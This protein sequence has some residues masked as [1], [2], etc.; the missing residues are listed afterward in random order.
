MAQEFETRVLDI[1]VK[2]I[3]DKLTKLGAK[4]ED[5]VLMKRWVFD[6]D[7]P[8]QQ[9]IRLRD[10][11]KK[12]TI[13]YKNRTGSGISE[14][15]ELEVEVSDF[16]ESAKILSK[17]KFKETFYQEN[18]RKIF[19]LNDIEFAIDT[20]P[21]IPPYLEIESD[22]EEKVKEGLALL[23]LQG[24]DVGNISVKETYDRYGVKLHSFKELRF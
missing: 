15:E 23:G 7:G 17:L 14:T 11:G 1:D 6:I 19:L 18:K 13:A 22:S 4:V 3:E 12:V 8:N 2:K 20:W 9:W 5:E 16:E 24:K 21:K 10:N